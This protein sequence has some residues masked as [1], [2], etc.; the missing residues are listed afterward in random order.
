MPKYLSEAQA[1]YVKKNQTLCKKLDKRIE[2]LQKKH[3]NLWA[4]SGWI[5]I[6]AAALTDKI[7]EH[8]PQNEVEM[9]GPFGLGA[10]VHI[11][12]FVDKEAALRDK[13]DDGNYI[14]GITITPGDLDKGELRLVDTFTN[15]GGYQPGTIGALNGFNHP[16]M[17]MPETFEELIAFLERKE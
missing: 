10:K 9:L 4:C 16:E 7:S 8:Y 15:T 17:D 14:G 2:E 13:Y 6:I 11:S 3:S 12:V 5:T 1:E